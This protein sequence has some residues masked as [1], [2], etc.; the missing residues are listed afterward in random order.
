LIQQNRHKL[1]KSKPHNSWISKTFI[2]IS[3][4]AIPSWGQQQQF[5]K[6]NERNASRR[7]MES[8]GELPFFANMIG[9]I[10]DQRAAADAAHLLPMKY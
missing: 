10:H 6:I 1:F 2:T 8:A 9:I 7:M 4:I 3:K 5:L